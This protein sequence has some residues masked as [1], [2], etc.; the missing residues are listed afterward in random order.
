MPPHGRLEVICGPMFSGKTSAL[1]GALRAPESGGALGGPS[2]RAIAIKP[3]R[4]DRYAADELVS[5]AGARLA[6]VSVGSA[7]DVARA[8]GDS[9]L[10]GIDEAHFFG[11]GLVQPVLALV[12]RGARV[13]VAGL[14]RDHR[15]EPFEPFPRLLIEADA[16]M[17]LTTACAVCGGPAVHSQRMV[18]SDDRIVVGGAG[19]YEAR[20]RRCF[21]GGR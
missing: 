7:T 11:A 4:D 10:V 1:I 20:C 6:A 17:K 18:Q 16:V 13:I 2:T 9:A 19:D 14:E 8:A 3:A 21:E 12:R 5:H 15:G